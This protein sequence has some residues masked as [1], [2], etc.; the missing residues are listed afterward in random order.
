VL[1]VGLVVLITRGLGAKGAGVLF[2]AIALFTILTNAAELGADTGLVRFVAR[3]RA[4]ARTP[5]I[6]PMLGVAIWPVA[7]ASALLGAV[8]LVAAPTLA[9]LL[10]DP[11]QRQDAVTYLRVMAPFVPLGTV[12]T[13]ALAGTR[14]FGTVRPYVAVQNILV[15]VARPVLVAVV[16]LAGLGSVAIALAWALPLGLGCV[17]GLV[18]LFAFLARAERQA[19]G[20][21]ARRSLREIGSEFWR[22]SVPR[23]VAGFFQIAILWVDV[24][25]VGVFRP[26]SDVGVYSAVSRTVMAGTLVLQAVRLAVA[27]QISRLLAIDD[28]S[29]AQTVFQ[30]ATWW[31]IAASWPIYITLAVFAPLVLRAFGPGFA[32]GEAA[33]TVLAL[34]MLVDMG[35]GNVSTVLLMAGKSSWNLVNTGVSVVMNVGLNLILIPRLGIVGAALAWAASIVVE[36]LAAV[37][38]VEVLVS[39]RPFGT[40]YPVVTL[41]A[42]ACIGGVALAARAALG[43]TLV[44]LIATAVVGG[45]LYAFVLWRNRRTLNLPALWSALRPVGRPVP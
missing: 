42:V 8:V 32:T 29:R 7:G 45:G 21:I 2:L 12:M 13:V 30:N 19:A 44:A 28:R 31:L 5:E 9:H 25:L 16:L 34:A 38:E 39:L 10:V 4:L 43:A 17:A 3:N 33:L 20:P 37:I 40:G 36:N 23:G 14:G 41:A 26:D 24:L 6:R 1:G 27:P 35:T 18:L 15:P 22:F 11:G